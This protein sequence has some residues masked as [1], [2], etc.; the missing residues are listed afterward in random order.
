MSNGV[1]V[2]ELSEWVVRLSWV[3]REGDDG[4]VVMMLNLWKWQEVEESWKWFGR[5][6]RLN[7]RF[8]SHSRKEFGRERQDSKDWAWREALS[9]EPFSRKGPLKEVGG[10]QDSVGWLTEQG[11]QD[12]KVIFPERRRITFFWVQRE[13]ENMLEAMIVEVHI[14]WLWFWWSRKPSEFF[15]WEGDRVRLWTVQRGVSYWVLPTDQALR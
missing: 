5:E 6:R 4:S 14:K 3:G 1:W 13:Y 7:S 12:G 11:G 10:K 8:K 15:V 9:K 2:D